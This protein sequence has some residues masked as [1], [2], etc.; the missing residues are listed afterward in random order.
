MDFESAP[1]FD[2]SDVPVML[3]LALCFRGMIIREVDIH[4]KENFM[5]HPG[6]VDLL[7]DRMTCL[8]VCIIWFH[9]FLSATTFGMISVFS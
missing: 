1:T 9:F 4:D 3:A 6:L 2:P 8:H 7:Q 5:V